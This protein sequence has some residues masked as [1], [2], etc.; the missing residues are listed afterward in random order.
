MN[1][2]A[3]LVPHFFVKEPIPEITDPDFLDAIEK[4]RLAPSAQ[5]AMQEAMDILRVKYEAKRFETYFL[6]PLIFE[7][8]PNVLWKRHGFMHC[9]QQNFLFRILMIKS[10]K[11][12]D[13]RITL[14]HS[15]VWY[16]SPHQYL[17]IHL[18]DK[19]IAVDP[20]NY[21]L[22]ATLGKYAS[23]FGMRSL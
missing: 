22:G 19:T 11:L 8:D 18:P 23:G 17:K 6:Y 3:I 5:I 14:G 9:P 12:T 13:D 4:V 1:I 20:W 16:I 2:P 10:G 15:L 7:K 21:D